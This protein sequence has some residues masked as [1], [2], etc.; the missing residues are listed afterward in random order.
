VPEALSIN[1]LVGELEARGIVVERMRN[2][3][4]R[5]EELFVKMTAKPDTEML[6]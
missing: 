6:A 3:V 4:N 2:K 5:L 1:D